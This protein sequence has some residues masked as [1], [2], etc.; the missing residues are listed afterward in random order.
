M[1]PDP[2]IVKSTKHTCKSKGC[3]NPV[4][5]RPFKGSKKLYPEGKCGVCMSTWKRYRMTGPER[6]QYV[7]NGGVLELARIKKKKGKKCLE[8]TS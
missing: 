3:N 1:S 4:R 2:I 8:V 5:M 6:D 7:A